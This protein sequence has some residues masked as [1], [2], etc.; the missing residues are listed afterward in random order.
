VLEVL[1]DLAALLAERGEIYEAGGILATVVNDPAASRLIRQRSENLLDDLEQRL[2]GNRRLDLH[3][4]AAD[5]TV[6]ML[7]KAFLA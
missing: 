1:V 6:D 5:T 7:A 2:P 4:H 3:E